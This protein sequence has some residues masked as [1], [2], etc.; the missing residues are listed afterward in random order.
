[1]ELNNLRNDALDA[2]EAQ[3]QGKPVEQDHRCNLE[4][5]GEPTLDEIKD[6]V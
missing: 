2:I 4:G 1:V 6:R 3:L 5:G